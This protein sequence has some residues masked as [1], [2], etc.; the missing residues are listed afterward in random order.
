MAMRQPGEEMEDGRLRAVT[1]K[2]A[3]WQSACGAGFAVLLL[4][5]LA[6]GYLRLF[7]P[8]DFDLFAG[9]ASPLTGI[10]VPDADFAVNYRSFS[11]FSADN[12]ERIGPLLP[13]AGDGKPTWA[14]FGNSF[15]HAPGMLGD[16]ARDRL[17]DHRIFFLGRNEPLVVRLAQIKLL[18][19]NGL[20]PER[21]FI[22]LMPI[23]M[24]T[25]GPQPLSSLQVT[26]RGALTYRA[27]L[28]AGPL[29]WAV[30]HS[31]LARLTW[32]RTGRQVGNPQFRAA[33]LDQGLDPVLCDDL[34]CLFGNLARITGEHNVPVTI[35][36]IPAYQQVLRGDGF[37]FQDALTTLLRPQGYD[38]FDPRAAFLA[39][40]EPAGLYL[41]D[42]HLTPRGNQLLLREMLAH[43]GAAPHL[44]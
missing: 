30:E 1:R 16:T 20:R 3:F 41:P 17:T 26:P 7:P 32:Y 8:K 35:I 15:V 40:P 14:F 34:S 36:L 39:A 42:W 22:E 2:T 24:L 44:S 28:P 6:E 31:E 23:D 4:A 10:Y 12:A 9:E 29:G 38:I 21:I 25:L 11:A 37:G 27:R 18:L 19:Q 33:A 43:V 5:G 13:L